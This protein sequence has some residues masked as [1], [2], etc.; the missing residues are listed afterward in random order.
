M[1]DEEKLRL[2]EELRL[3]IL[4]ELREAAE[5]NNARKASPKALTGVM[6]KWVGGN[7]NGLFCE[8]LPKTKV[9]DTWEHVRRIVCNLMNVS[10]VRELRDP[11]RAAHI[12]DRLCTVIWELGKEN[13]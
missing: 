7:R 1:T 5:I 6:D 3:E 4:E 9:Y 11:D 13:G 10:Y 12:A 2:K 8:M